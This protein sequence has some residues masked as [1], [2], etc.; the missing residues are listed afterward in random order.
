MKKAFVQFTVLDSQDKL[1]MKAGELFSSRWKDRTRVRLDRGSQRSLDP[2]WKLIVGTAQQ[3]AV[4]SA[5][6]AA[7]LAV[8]DQPQAYAIAV[9]GRTLTV[10]GADGHGGSP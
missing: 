2:A 10:C 6:T 3:L 4:R 8:P 9:A 1:V 7:G 5:I